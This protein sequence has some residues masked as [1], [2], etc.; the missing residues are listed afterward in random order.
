MGERGND[1]IAALLGADRPALLPYLTAGI[2]DAGS[3]PEVFA[4]MEEADGFEVGIPYADPLMDGPV[5]AAAGRA[6]IERGMTVRG[7]IDIIAAVARRT[8]KPVIAMT[9]TNPILAFGVDDFLSAI[10]EAGASGLI[11]ADLPVEES[12]PFMAA[13]GAHGLGMAL[14]VAPTT[15]PQRLSD[16]AARRPAFLYGVA[17]LGVTG[18]RDRLADTAA[19]LSKR[20]RLATDLPLVL[21]VGISTPAQASEA[22]SLADGI[23]VGSAIVNTVMEADSGAAA[24]KAVAVQ[25]AALRAAMD[26]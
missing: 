3:S 23:I 12:G 4:A 19:A 25:V 1:R 22:A 5:I 17:T 14:F 18:V 11:V 8:A 9:Y 21:G 10:G 2:P 24:A 15:T 6:A 16:I 26:G 13:A 20:V 7:A